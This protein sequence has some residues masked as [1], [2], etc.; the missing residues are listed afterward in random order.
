MSSGTPSSHTSNPGEASTLLKRSASVLPFLGGVV[1]FQVQYADA[2][3]R[4]TLNLL[5]EPRQIRRRRRRPQT[6][7]PPTRTSA[8]GRAGPVSRV[9]GQRQQTGRGAGDARPGIVVA[10]AVGRPQ[11]SQERQR[12][13]GAAARRQHA[14]GRGVLQLGDARRAS[15]PSRPGPSATSSACCSASWSG[16]RLRA[17]ASAG[18][19]QG[20]KSA[21]ASD[22]NVRSRLARS[23]LGSMASTGMPSMA[24]SS[25]RPMPRPGLAAAGHADAD[26][27][28]DQV[29]RVVEDQVVAP[30]RAP[31]GRTACRGR[32]ARVSRSRP[33][34][35]S[36]YASAPERTRSP[37]RAFGARNAG[38][39]TGWCGSRRSTPRSGA[40]LGKKVSELG[41]RVE[42]SPVQ[43]YV[44]QLYH[45]LDRRGL[46]AFR[47]VCYLTDEWGC[48]DQ[49][50][51]LG[52]PFYL[53]DPTLRSLE[54]AVDALESE[55]QIMMYMR[56]EAGHVFNYAYRLYTTP[57][58]RAL[59]GPFFRAYRDEYRPVPF[60]KQFVRHIEGWYAQK[61][62]GRGLCRDV[63]RLA[64]AAQPLAPPVQ[65]LAGHP[66]AALR[67]SHGQG[68]RHRRADRQDRRGRHHAGRHEADGGAVL[69]AGG[70]GAADAHRGRARRPPRPGVP[71][72]PAQG[73]EA[74]GGDHPPP[75]AANWSR[76]SRTGRACRDPSSRAWWIR[77]CAPASG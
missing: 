25:M 48:P 26:G 38:I 15:G 61:H 74:G 2:V 67:G 19:T 72:A 33:A 68:V 8:R 9:A 21:G 29:L 34:C 12:R 20:R 14:H 58:W 30:L 3:E 71:D 22:G 7:G 41:L 63:R 52:I 53:A 42:G 39:I 44:D 46:K 24:A 57:E 1:R 5:D 32:T 13:A 55:R 17:A 6:R 77:W 62:P 75:R 10:L 31:R 47:P 28:R 59:F 27:V 70:A 66:Q 56:H 23:P 36:S 4:G 54:H 69:R 76:R 45:E 50:P 16:V 49:Q 51:V 64:D 60:S 65:G 35:P 40:C 11:R 73:V 43:K 18:S 37:D